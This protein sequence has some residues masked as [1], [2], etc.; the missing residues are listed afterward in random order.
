MDISQYLL[1]EYLIIWLAMSFILFIGWLSVVLDPRSSATLNIIVTIISA[2]LGLPLTLIIL[3]S[4][5]FIRFIKFFKKHS[6]QLAK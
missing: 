4:Y 5:C 6:K 2:I 1:L 3:I